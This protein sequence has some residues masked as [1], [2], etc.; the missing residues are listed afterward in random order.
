MLCN[1]LARGL[2]ISW[3]PKS[4]PAEKIEDTAVESSRKAAAKEKENIIQSFPVD[5]SGFPDIKAALEVQT[6]DIL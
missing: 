6:P 3:I 5:P 2:I 1:A 4:K